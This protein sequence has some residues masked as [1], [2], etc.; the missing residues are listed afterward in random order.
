MYVPVCFYNTSE[1]SEITAPEQITITLQ[2]PRAVLATINKDTLAI[3]IDAQKLKAGKN[4]LYIGTD[5]L[6]LPE[7]IKLVHYNPANSV[8]QVNHKDHIKST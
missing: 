2:A 3:H 8:I 7:T 5:N 6:F 4:P 1:N